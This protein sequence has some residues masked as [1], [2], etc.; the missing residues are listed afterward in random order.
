MNSGTLRKSRKLHDSTKAAHP[1]VVV[2]SYKQFS[3]GE[4]FCDCVGSEIRERYFKSDV[5]DHELF[6]ACSNSAITET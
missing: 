2:F 5:W 1:D 3:E 6:S 4:L